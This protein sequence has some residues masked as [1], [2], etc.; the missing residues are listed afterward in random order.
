MKVHHLPDIVLLVP[1][2]R[3]LRLAGMGAIVAAI[4]SPQSVKLFFMG[5]FLPPLSH[6]PVNVLDDQDV[7]NARRVLSKDVHMWIQDG[8]AHHFEVLAQD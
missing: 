3:L 8:R 1:H 4:K 7:G 2:S 6:S 5:M